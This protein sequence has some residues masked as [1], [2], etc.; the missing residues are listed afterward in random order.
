MLQDYSYLLYGNRL[1]VSL[2]KR[3]YCVITVITR[4]RELWGKLKE[5]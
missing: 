5:K 2:E 1:G 4:G 3:I